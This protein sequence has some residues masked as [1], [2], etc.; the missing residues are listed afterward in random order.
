VPG[1]KQGIDGLRTRIP[2]VLRRT[3]AGAGVALALASC[4]DLSLVSSLRQEAPGALRFSPPDPVIPLNASITFSVMGG[5]PPYSIAPSS[6]SVT[7]LDDHTWQFP[8]QPSNGD[9][10]IQVS[11]WAGKTATSDVRVYAGAGPQ[12]NVT[13]V[14]LPAGTGWTFTV[15]SGGTGPYTWEVDGVAKATGTSYAFSSSVTGMYVVA[16]IDSLGVSQVATADVVPSGI[17]VDPLSITPTSAGT[18]PGGRIAFTALGGSGSY[19]FSASAG[20]IVD[21]N[22]AT[23]TAP[24]ATGSY[25]KAITLA[26]TGGGLPS[27][28][29]ADVIVTASGTLPLITP[30]SVTVSV[31]GDT[32]Q[33][34]ASGGT[35]PYTYSL[36]R[37]DI[38]SIDAATGLYTQLAAGPVLVTVADKDGL[39]DKARVKWK[40]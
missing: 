33:F 11:D 16:V 18:V 9:F 5:I 25:A 23:Y 37:P 21:A 22:P 40:P 26:D 10:A 7:A 35:G 31:V 6:V 20:T 32:V 36:N 24:P 15:V 13:E 29:Y 2:R 28:V 34:T 12:L 3:L 30:N 17:G 1:R 38:G 14:T 19:H 39:T 4:G 8:G 27:P